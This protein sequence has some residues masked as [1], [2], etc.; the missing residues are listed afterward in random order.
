L[1]ELPAVSM[2]ESLEHTAAG[3]KRTIAETDDITLLAMEIL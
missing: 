1:C 2:L 3:W